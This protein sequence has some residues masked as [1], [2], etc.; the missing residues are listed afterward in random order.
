MMKV[1]DLF[2]VRYGVNLELNALQHDPNGVNFVSRTSKNNGVAARVR[3]LPGVAPLVAGTLSVAGGGSVMETF[4]QNEPYYSGRDLYCLTA[5][6]PLTDAQKLYYCDCLRANKYR[7][8]YG[9]QANR[10]LRDLLIPAIEAI[11]D[12][13][14]KITKDVLKGENAPASFGP[15][16]VLETSGWKIYTLLELFTLHKGKRLTRAAMTPGETPFIGAIDGNNGTREFISDA[17]QHPA[18][19]INLSCVSSVL[20]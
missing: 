18:G 3:A 8:S 4:L 6:R 14:G 5:L 19:T 10:T 16:L 11:P 1:T 9:R 17:A 2:D 20:P 12:W 7:Y 15:P 13:V